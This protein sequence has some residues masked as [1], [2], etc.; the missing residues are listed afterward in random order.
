[1]PKSSVK[2]SNNRRTRRR[3]SLDYR[4][5]FK[6]RWQ[7]FMRGEFEGPAEIAFEFGCDYGTAEGWEEGRN[8]P[9]GPFVG[10]AYARWPEKAAAYL[11]GSDA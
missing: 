5:N 7:A 1:M 9:S 11:R 4:T 6:D 2:H 8:G 10:L 3:V